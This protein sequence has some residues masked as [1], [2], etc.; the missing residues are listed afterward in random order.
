MALV[1]YA[2]VVRFCFWNQGYIL[3]VP[4]NIDFIVSLCGVSLQMPYLEMSSV[5]SLENVAL[6]ARMMR[7]PHVSAE[8]KG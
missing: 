4:L 3:D 6:I 1:S 5:K 8:R 2:P 7:L